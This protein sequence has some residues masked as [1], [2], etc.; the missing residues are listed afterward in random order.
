MRVLAERAHGYLDY[1]TIVYLAIAPS[2]FGLSGSPAAVFYVLAMVHLCLTL[3]TAFALGAVRLVPFRWHGG[4]EW[5]AALLLGSMPWLAGYV[6]DTVARNVSVATAIGIGIV[7][8]LTDYHHVGA[9]T[10][11]R[12]LAEEPDTEG[13]GSDRLPEQ[14]T[15]RPSF[16]A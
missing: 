12:A 16:G 1:A 10:H 13:P 6:Q 5:A 3:S 11:E 14:H 4:L 8:L 15:S 7:S 2:L 9:T